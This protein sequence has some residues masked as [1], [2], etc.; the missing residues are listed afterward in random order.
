MDNSTSFDEEPSP[1][2]S[3]LDEESKVW[4]EE[5]LIP[6]LRLVL[7]EKDSLA[8]YEIMPTEIPVVMS[9]M[10]FLEIKFCANEEKLYSL[11][12]KRP[13][14]SELM[15]ELTQS[16]SLF[17]NEIL[18]YNKYVKN[19]EDYPRCFFTLEEPPGN[20]VIILENISKRGYHVCP[21]KVNLDIKYVVA[22]MQ[23]IG[24]FHAK[25]YV[26]KEKCPSEF[27]EMVDN[28][29]ESRYTRECRENNNFPLL[30]NSLAKRVI[31]RLRG[32]NYD[33][34][35]CDKAEVFFNNAFENVMMAA[36]NSKLPLATLCHGDF[37]RNNT[38]FRE[39]DSG[40]KAMLFDFALITYGS[41]TIDLST[42]LCLSAKREDRK[43][44][45]SEIF[46]AYHNSLMDYLKEAGLKNLEG[47]SKERFFEDYKRHALFG[48]FI[49]SFF[50][51]VLLEM[52][53]PNF[54]EMASEEKLL[55]SISNIGGDKFTEVVTEMLLDMREM[56]CLDHVVN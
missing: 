12:V 2:S 49:A 34:V 31:E 7:N 47:F 25:A 55:A 38:F 33:K 22:A 26:Q 20:S 8:K 1:E 15:R 23:E 28:I 24:K 13:T 52:D 50:L 43:N 44:R 21:Q 36:I 9:S 53:V 6:N 40:V 29:Q 39:S 46:G 11:V 17:H 41:P 16:D 4:L 30:I 5:K 3:I 37:T 35:F 51:P 54:E 45:I 56:G 18:F 27:F 42:F 32:E 48:Y 19:S 10:F 14:R